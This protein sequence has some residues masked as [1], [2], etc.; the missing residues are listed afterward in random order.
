[1]TCS[2]KRETK[3]CLIVLWFEL[4]YIFLYVGYFNGKSSICVNFANCSKSPKPNSSS[5]NQGFG[6]TEEGLLTV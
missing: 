6:V 1:M 4:F 5:Q 3:S 2:L